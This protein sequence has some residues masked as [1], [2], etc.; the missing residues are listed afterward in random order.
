MSLPLEVH[1]ECQR[2]RWRHPCTAVNTDIVDS[3][4][5]NYIDALALVAHELRSPASVVSGYLRLLQQDPDGLTGHQRRMADEAGRACTRML[6]LLQEVGELASLESSE[7]VPGPIGV[8]VFSICHDALKSADL[9]TADGQTPVFMCAES[10]RSVVVDGNATWLK[11]AFG[12][13]MAATVREHRTEPL[14]CHGFVCQGGEGSRD[15]VIVF[16]PRGL[17]ASRDDLA[18]R[19]ETFNRWR[20]G[21]G[22]SLPIACRI[23]E[24]HN[25]RVWSPGG[26]GSRASAWSLPIAPSRSAPL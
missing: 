23:I 9:Q 14:E 25:G 13:L 6:R 10:D 26:A 16:G 22:L 8:P 1:V 12:A 11:R 18:A 5:A 21:T 15:A 7:P 4:H 3:L 2:R 20:G 17:G 19:G 24:A